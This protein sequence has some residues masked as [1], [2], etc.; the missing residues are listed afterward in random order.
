MKVVT[1]REIKPE[2]KNAFITAMQRSQSLH[3]P[4]VKAPLT[5]QEFTEYFQRSQQLNQKSFFVCDEN[6]NIAGVF[7]LS[8]IVRG[9]F[10]NAYLGFYAA[11]DFAEKGYMS[12]GLKLVLK[13]V[14]NELS[15]HRLEANI[16]PENI[17]SI[18]LVKNNGFRNEGYS[19][20]YLK[21]NGFWRGHEHWAMTLE[22]FQE[23]KYNR[24]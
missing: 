22:D 5:C 24:E 9:L 18:N 15:L 13:K 23:D 16:Q 2:D 1:I 12:A 21:I 14:F 8:E 17:H 6:N 4:W 11:I 3:H 19:P 10:Q 7:N 20:N